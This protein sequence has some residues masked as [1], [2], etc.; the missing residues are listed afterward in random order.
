MKKMIAK[1][2]YELLEIYPYKD[3]SV[4]I[5]CESV[6][7]SRPTFYNHFPSKD[8]LVKWMVRQDYH[9]N[10]VPLFKHHLG[11]TGVQSF[12]T[13]I[14]GQEGFYRR[15][16][17]HDEGIFLFNCLVAAY[18]SGVDISSSY[19]RPPTHELPSINPDVYR[20]YSTTGIAAVVTYWIENNMTIPIKEIAGD[21]Y[22]MI[23]NPLEV[24]RDNCLKQNIE[25]PHVV[26]K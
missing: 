22:L 12:F 8:A 23:G 21:L 16:Y 7:V 4:R 24:V 3:V 19:S 26:G 9:E 15:L 1:S 6:P 25:R 11:T 5:L 10:A 14:K 2:M 17:D 18:D 13:Y 20:R